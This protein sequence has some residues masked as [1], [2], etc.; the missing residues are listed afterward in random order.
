M[1]LFVSGEF[2]QL[3]EDCGKIS[4]L[5]CSRLV[6]KLVSEYV[7]HLTPTMEFS[8]GYARLEVISVFSSV[9]LC[10]LGSVFIVKEGIE[11]FFHVHHPHAS[12]GG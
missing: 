3:I 11:G 5:F 10:I 1:F 4:V 9:T 7:P 8:F 12:E 6:V 2:K